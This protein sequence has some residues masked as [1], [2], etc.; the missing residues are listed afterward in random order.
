VG[1]AVGAAV[2]TITAERS[3][4]RSRQPE[5]GAPPVQRVRRRLRLPRRRTFSVPL[6]GVV[7]LASFAV[8]TLYGSGWLRVER[9]TVS[10]TRV[11]TEGQVRDAAAVPAGVPLISVDKEAVAGRLTTGLRRIASVEVVRNWPHGIALKVTERTPEVLMEKPGDSGKYL[12]VDAEGVR[13]VTVGNRTKG[14][15]LLTMEVDKSPSNRRFGAER[16]RREAATAAAALPESVRRDTRTIR[17][18][19]Y[20]SI[21][22]ELSGNRTVTWGSSEYASVKARSLTAL[23]KAEKDAGHFDVSVPSAPAASAS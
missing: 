4:G 14:V 23:M 18:R 19:S 1:R 10:G 8:W 2:G 3:G 6:C 9:V 12:E 5:A 16:L 7:A 11:L 15:P 17:M 21:A 13:Y 20:D 22:L